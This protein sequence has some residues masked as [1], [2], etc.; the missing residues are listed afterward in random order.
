MRAAESGHNETVQTLIA[1]G[2]DM[3]IQAVKVLV[4][5]H[6][7]VYCFMLTQLSL[8]ISHVSLQIDAVCMF[9][10]NQPNILVSC[11]NVIFLKQLNYINF[12]I[13]RCLE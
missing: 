4:S 13:H 11:Y 10:L 1:A 5:C 9:Q 3:N 7:F 6:I 8:T 2:A 12:Y